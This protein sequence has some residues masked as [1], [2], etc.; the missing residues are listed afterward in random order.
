MVSPL[1]NEHIEYAINIIEHCQVNTIF[2]FN[3]QV[4]AFPGVVEFFG[5]GDS[6]KGRYL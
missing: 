1:R 2:L 4:V 5:L 3:T 6:T